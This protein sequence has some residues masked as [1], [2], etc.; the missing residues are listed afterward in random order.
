MKG[1]TVFLAALMVLAIA[2]PAPAEVITLTDGTV[3]Q[4]KIL[5]GDEKGL[6]MQRFDT[7]GIVF[8]PWH[9]LIERDRDRIRR[10]R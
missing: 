1:A 9:F 2:A 3:L 10:D 4:G 5:D 8:L 6:R 7:G